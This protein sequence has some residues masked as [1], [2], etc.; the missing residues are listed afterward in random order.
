MLVNFASCMPTVRGASDLL[1]DL[2]Q[3]PAAAVTGVFVML[4]GSPAA[5]EAAAKAS[6]EATAAPATVYALAD[7]GPADGLA[8]AC[9]AVPAASSWSA[10]TGTWRRSCPG[11]S[12][13]PWPAVMRR[14]CAG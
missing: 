1:G 9:A 11:S 14:A 13:A 4:L 7:L 12:G 8:G 5:M 2:E 6:R 3:Q 10:R